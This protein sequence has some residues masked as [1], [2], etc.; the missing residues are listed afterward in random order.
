MS[1]NIHN[2]KSKD[3]LDFL[4]KNWFEKSNQKGSHVQLKKW[5]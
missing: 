5:V 3:I 2:I 1:P 4:L